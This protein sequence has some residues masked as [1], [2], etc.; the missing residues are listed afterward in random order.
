M[1]VY[2]FTTLTFFLSS[3]SQTLFANTAN[4]EARRSGI[5]GFVANPKR[6]EW[7]ARGSHNGDHVVAEKAPSS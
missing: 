5:H 3:H 2:D 6:R 4:G 7:W 1:L